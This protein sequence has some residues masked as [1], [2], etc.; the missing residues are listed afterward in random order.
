MQKYF[1][2]KSI[3]QCCSL[4]FIMKVA[5]SVIRT[6]AGEL[7]LMEAE[8]KQRFGV[9][10]GGVGGGCMVHTWHWGEPNHKL[11]DSLTKWGGGWGT[12]P[13]VTHLDFEESSFSFLKHIQPSPTVYDNS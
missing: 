6:I 13:K 3:M 9:H 5:Y 2:A 7:I 8:A 10:V 12:V 4:I 1:C 11:A